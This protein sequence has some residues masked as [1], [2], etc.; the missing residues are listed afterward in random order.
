MGKHEAI[1]SKNP[2]KPKDPIKPRDHGSVRQ[3]LFGASL[4]AAL[5]GTSLAGATSFQVGNVKGRF[6]T[7]LSYGASMRTE[8]RDSDLVDPPPTA[9][10][11]AN[12][13]GD[14]NFDQWEVFGHTLKG[15][16]ELEFSLGEGFGGLLSGAWFYDF[17][18]DHKE[19]NRAARNRAESHGD[20][21]DAYLYKTFG[22]NEQYHVRAGKQVISW[23]ENTF[24]A[25]SLNDIN[26]VDV[27]KL[28]QPGVELKDALLPT[29]AVYG[30]W[31]FSN[32]LTFE[33]F[34][35]LGFDE[36]K[37][38]PSGTFFATNDFLSDGGG[39]DSADGVFDGLCLTPDGF[40]CAFA[41]GTLRA[42]DRI[43]SYGGQWG[44]ASRVFLPEVGEA[45]LELGFYY[46]NLHD[47]S[48][49]ISM[50]SDGVA[51]PG[52][53]RFFVEYPEDI[54]RWGVSFNYNFVS[55]ALSGE[56]SHRDNATYQ[57]AAF[58][59]ASFAD[60]DGTPSEFRGWTRIERD[61]VQ[62][63]A[64]RN[65]AGPLF[66]FAGNDA[67]SFIGE[68]YYGWADLPSLAAFAPLGVPF[69]KGAAFDEFDENFWGFQ[70]AFTMNYNSLIGP[71]NFVPSLAY[72][73]NVDGNS[74]DGLF[75]EDNKSMGLNLNFDY[76][77]RW[78]W[79]LSHTWTWGGDNARAD[80]DFLSAN[81]SYA[82]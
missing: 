42:P 45:G 49:A 60:A 41:A 11:S 64:N 82:F 76:G 46:E 70:A 12:Q 10:G 44:L 39:F 53:N 73:W 80:R 16:H 17:A 3:C 28:R 57:G 23:G 26:T 1:K 43:P 2:V 35:L 78:K 54:E 38:D 50:L 58:I 48:P 24:I 37:I 25:G 22:A 68:A 29:P 62:M 6:D 69:N 36:T 52:G 55:W 72:S 61:Q 47:H 75:V 63:T 71:V 15:T 13:F 31:A 14:R 40:S 33:G 51:G 9:A 79:G 34:Y 7:N 59:G 30:S 77:L 20:I 19:L 21:L 66:G 67:Y 56:W 18:A 8:P 81:I 32:R 74:P 5:L 27:T 65:W 4:L